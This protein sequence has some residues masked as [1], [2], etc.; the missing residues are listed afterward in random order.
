MESPQ[1]DRDRAVKLH[2]EMVRTLRAQELQTG[3]LKHARK[4][5]SAALD[6]YISTL[7]K[8]SQTPCSHQ[9]VPL[10]NSLVAHRAQG[11]DIEN[12][13]SYEEAFL[14]AVKQNAPMLYSEIFDVMSTFNIA[15]SNVQKVQ[16][17]LNQ[18]SD[19]LT[20]LD[21]RIH[22]MLHKYPEGE[23]PVAVSSSSPPPVE[24][25]YDM[26]SPR[27]Y[28]Y[29]RDAA[30]RELSGTNANYTLAA[31]EADEKWSDHVSVAR[32]HTTDHDS[33]TE[34]QV[35]P[36]NEERGLSPPQYEYQ[37]RSV[38][39]DGN[40]HDRSPQERTS[41]QSPF[42]RY[43][44]YRRTYGCR[45]SNDPL[46]SPPFAMVPSSPSTKQAA[47]AC[48]PLA[49]AIAS[50][51][52]AVNHEL[53]EFRSRQQAVVPDTRPVAKPPPFQQ[54][55]EPNFTEK[56]AKIV[57]E[58]LAVL[59]NEGHAVPSSVQNLKDT[60][61]TFLLLCQ[62]VLE[63]TQKIPV[64]EPETKLLVGKTKVDKKLKDADRFDKYSLHG[65]LYAPT[66]V[67]DLSRFRTNRRI[68]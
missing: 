33:G 4:V 61:K 44:R 41:V 51:E 37:E 64:K 68:G 18:L 54:S 14:V 67:V 30:Q 50:Q 60:T 12:L 5:H 9:A 7:S 10:L 8:L 2:H 21:E 11:D 56:D 53:D 52:L 6:K 34:D 16:D 29:R 19:R 35:N 62:R 26:T 27:G 58:A 20:R 25:G 1:T 63:K 17:K 43:S 49:V 39:L 38:E 31:Q 23:S 36:T 28:R 57:D 42:A 13:I 32:S 47:P 55:T 66:K 22:Q 40:R 59:R 48:V 65:G 24:R 46:V 45:F 15:S 3:Q